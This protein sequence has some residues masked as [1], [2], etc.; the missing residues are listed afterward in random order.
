[1]ETS[2]HPT[3]KF[4]SIWVEKMKL[5]RRIAPHEESQNL[6]FVKIL[7]SFLK[8]F[9]SVS[10]I[11]GFVHVTA[12]KRHPSEAIIWLALIGTGVFGASILSSATWKRYQENPTVISMERDRFTWNTSFPAA[13]ICPTSKVHEDLLKGVLQN[14][15]VK[16]KTAL[17]AFLRTLAE[18]NYKN[19]D[20]V[21]PYYELPSE[22]FMKILLQLQYEFKPLVSNSGLQSNK[23]YLEKT[24]TEMGICYSYNSNLA[25]YNSP[26]YREKK[27]W[28]VYTETRTLF[29][30]PLDGEI[31]A[32]VVNMST[33]FHI[34]LHGP[35]EVVDI[36]S[37]SLYSPDGF[38]LQ[39]YLS[40]LTIFTSQ[41]AREL[42]INQRKCQFY[43]ESNLRHSPVYSYLLCRMECRITLSKRLCGCIPH[44][45]RNLGLSI[46]RY[47]R[48]VTLIIFVVADDRVCNASGLHCL[49]KYSDRLI[50]LKRDCSCYS[51]CDEVN[52]VIEDKDTREWFLGSNLQWGLKEYP[53]MRLRRDVIF[54]FT[55]VLVY[56]GG[57]AGLFLGCSV[58][59]FLEIVYFF[60]L[61]LFWF[62]TKYETGN[63]VK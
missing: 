37:K 15:N 12:E 6:P 46:D 30:H 47:T 3:R 59:S 8:L 35:Y 51:N 7:T 14:I 41:G 60:T 32:N 34:Y 52:Y 55:D 45:Y 29:V 10:T 4:A 61:R 43:H 20:K 42:A 17:E 19:F 53:R 24:I 48:Y 22:Q 50:T 38:F 13:T 31:F 49:S 56:I 39:L 2:T 23:Y 18:A 25:I 26:S 44:F 27:L 62:V 28:T 36:A 21:L 54:R 5:K 16:N 11:H 58:L 9:L 57:M 33:G 40:A 63:A 1:M